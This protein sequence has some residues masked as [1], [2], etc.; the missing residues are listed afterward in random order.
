MEKLYSALI[1]R[2]PNKILAV[3]KNY[4]DHAKEMGQAEAPKTPVIFQKA[5]SNVV[6][7]NEN[8]EESKFTIYSDGSVH[9]EIELGVVIGK[10]VRFYNR[11]KDWR[12]YIGGY[13]LCLDMTDRDL[14][15]E[16]KKKGLPWTLAKC[17]EN[18]M[19]VS[20]FIEESDV[21]DPHNLDLELKI[22]DNTVQKVNTKQMIF[23]IP[24]LLEF[25]SHYTTLHEGDLII[26][27]TPAGVGPVNDG[28]VLHGTL[29]EEGK[30]LQSFTFVCDKQPMPTCEA[31]GTDSS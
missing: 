9:H 24:Y 30:Q 23:D 1:R 12:S 15:A 19:P 6:P 7:P 11:D 28:D 4:L 26:T 29:S 25:L 18:F 21:E 10:T 31:F 14:Q 5:F 17:Q 22:N 20:E 16:F 3:G 27:G 13:F 8:G 2:Q